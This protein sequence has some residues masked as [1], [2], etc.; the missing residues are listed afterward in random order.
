MMDHDE[1]RELRAELSQQEGVAVIT[2]HGEIDAFAEPRLA[3]VY[4]QAEEP[5]PRAILLDLADVDYINSTGIALLVEL[6][7]RARKSRRPLLTCGLS[8]HYREIFRITRLADF[9]AIH[10]DVGDALESL[11]A[12]TA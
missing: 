10:D 2:L 8:E 11:S 4:A 12:E 5:D 3:D 1:A 7:A 6:L 9:M